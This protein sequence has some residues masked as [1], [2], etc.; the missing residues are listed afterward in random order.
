MAFSSTRH[1]ASAASKSAEVVKWQ[2]LERMPLVEIT[3]LIAEV[4]AWTGFSDCFPHLRTG[5]PIRSLSAL[6]AA[7]LA[8]ATNLGPRRMAE[9]SDG[10]SAR[11]IAWA[12]LFH[13]RHETF[14]TGVARIINAHSTIP[15][16]GS[17]APARPPPRTA[18]SFGPP[19]APRAEPTS[20]RITAAIPAVSSTPGSLTSTAIPTYCR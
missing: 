19:A 20:M 9:A 18:S 17:G 13:L 7:I 15:T 3:D 10:V 4:D 11:Q 16:P 1:S 12:R 2:C 5:D 6:H 14:K 8:D